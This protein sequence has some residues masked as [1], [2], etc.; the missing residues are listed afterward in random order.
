MGK[1]IKTASKM[2]EEYFRSNYIFITCGASK[3]RLSMNR[4]STFGIL[5]KVSQ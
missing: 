2:E 5:E 4:A 1:R 3:R